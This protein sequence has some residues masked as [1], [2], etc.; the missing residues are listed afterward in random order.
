MAYFGRLTHSLRSIEHSYRTQT[1]R[2]KERFTASHSPRST[3][4]HMKAPCPLDGLALEDRFLGTF[5]Y[6]RAVRLVHGQDLNF[7]APNRFSFIK[8]IWNEADQALGS[9]IVL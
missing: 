1:W 6:V 8:K 7:M 9:S 2:S 3:F 4:R 5:G